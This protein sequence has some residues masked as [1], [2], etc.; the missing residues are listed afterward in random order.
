MQIPLGT[1]ANQLHFQERKH[2][3]SQ[4]TI[5]ESRDTEASQR[6]S[7]P[8]KLI[9]Y[10]SRAVQLLEMIVNPNNQT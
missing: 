1:D 8:L 5:R 3:W 10:L 7:S 2:C 4:A 9:A 6:L